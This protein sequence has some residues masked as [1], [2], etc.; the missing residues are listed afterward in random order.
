MR[1]AVRKYGTNQWH[2]VASLLT[3]KTAAECRSRWFDCLDPRIS[4]SSWSSE[5]DRRLIELQNR[6]P[7]QWRSIAATLGSRSAEQ[8]HARIEALMSQVGAN[9]DNETKTGNFLW[10]IHKTSLGSDAE[11]QLIAEVRARL[12]N[13][14]G[15]KAKR[16]LREREEADKQF[17]NSIEQHRQKGGKL[18][19]LTSSSLTIPEVLPPGHLQ[20]L[21]SAISGPKRTE[22]SIKHQKRKPNRPHLDLPP[23]QIVKPARRFVFN[24]EL[25]QE[26]LEVLGTLPD[27]L[28]PSLIDHYRES[29]GNEDFNSSSSEKMSAP[30]KLE[31]SKM[32]IETESKVEFESEEPISE[33]AS[34][35][36]CD[37]QERHESLQEEPAHR[38]E[39]NNEIAE[40]IE[41]REALLRQIR[42]LGAV[43]RE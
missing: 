10:G 37:E 34:E 6:M 5:E 36:L 29:K 40:M 7:N 25:T 27:P 16:K 2:R 19:T 12:S 30:Y 39:P 8:C 15:R 14:L 28:K 18:K 17:W 33:I 4:A 38:V 1:S 3:S 42:K 35:T 11:K 9:V 20:P 24:A 13:S 41:E 21:K 26:V 32:E 23:P 22:P 31:R 43:L